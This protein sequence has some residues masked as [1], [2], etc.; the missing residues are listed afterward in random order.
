M[1]YLKTAR[2]VVID[3]APNEAAVVIE[4]LGRLGIGCIYLKGERLEDLP[5]QPLRGI[6]LAVL[7]L[8]LGT[9][10]SE[11]Q[12]ASA[13]ANVF[14]Q[15]ISADHGPLIVLLWTKHM[16]DVPAFKK[17]LFEIEPKFQDNIL[18]AN[19]EKPATPT[20][21]TPNRITKRINA[22]AGNWRPIDFLWQWEQLA[23]DAATETTATVARQVS[24]NAEIAKEESDEMRKDHWLSALK[25][26]LRRLVEAAGGRSANKKTANGDLIEAFT[27]IN[28]D[29]LELESFAAKQANLAALFEQASAVTAQQAG[30]LNRMVMIG[31]PFPGPQEIRPGNTY[32]LGANHGSFRPCGINAA[33]LKQEIVTDLERDREYKQQ[34]DLAKK[35]AGNASKAKAH[36]E[37]REKRRRELYKQCRVVIAEITPSCDFTQ[38]N[39]KVVRLAAGLLVPYELERLV[40]KKKESLRVFEP[41]VLP[42]IDGL[43]RLVFSGRH[44]YTMPDPQK[45]LP[46][47]PAFRLRSNVLADLRDWYGSQ[48]SRPGYLSLRPD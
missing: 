5:A 23:H 2:V 42:N 18:V 24:V 1:N 36:K 11:K 27:A 33:A 47:R 30:Q 17:V 45:L 9:T 6:R 16:E 25:R 28:D 35:N 19:L 38:R 4:A 32:I 8:H 48:G 21:A 43:W 26:L 31:S 41:V 40:P 14:R 22:L 34:N 37:A 13:T 7:D 3:D 39:R 29:R 10:G 46:T 20:A 12:I 44:L 15:T